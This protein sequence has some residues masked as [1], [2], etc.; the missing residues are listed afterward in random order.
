MVGFFTM[1]DRLCDYMGH[2][3]ED[4]VG[5]LISRLEGAAEAWLLGHGDT[6]SMWTYAVLKDNMISYFGEERRMNA[7]RLEMFEQGDQ[8]LAEY[9]AKFKTLAAS[10]TSILGSMVITDYYLRNLNS[11]DLSR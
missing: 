4:K 2:S 6:W 1:F 8:S 5:H 3:A 7:R 10:C 9:S 11:K